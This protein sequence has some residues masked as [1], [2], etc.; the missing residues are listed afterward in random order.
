MSLSGPSCFVRLFAVYTVCK[1]TVNVVGI[2][3]TRKTTGMPAVVLLCV[4]RIGGIPGPKTGQPGIASGKQQRHFSGLVPG[5]FVTMIYYRDCESLYNMVPTNITRI[6]IPSE[7]FFITTGVSGMSENNKIASINLTVTV[8]SLLRRAYVS[9]PYRC[10]GTCRINDEDG[11]GDGA[12][13]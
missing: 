5:E 2:V 10:T 12:F 1:L 7:D 13:R 8:N 6:R 3:H 4:V 9:K 11:D